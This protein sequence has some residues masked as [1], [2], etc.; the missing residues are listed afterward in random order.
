MVPYFADLTDIRAF[1]AQVGE[2]LRS[3]TAP[4]TL[5]SA[6]SGVPLPAARLRTLLTDASR[7]L[8]A[9]RVVA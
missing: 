5:P 7:V 4:Q 1:W 9:D 2:A 3:G 8:T 6:D